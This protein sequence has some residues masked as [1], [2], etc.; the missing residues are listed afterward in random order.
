MGDRE[1]DDLVAA[2]VDRVEAAWVRG[3]LPSRV[4]RRLCVELEQDLS[5]ALDAGA[6][7]AEVLATDPAELAHDVAA[8]AGEHV[9]AAGSGVSRLGLAV[10]GVAGSLVSVALVWFFVLPALADAIYPDTDGG[11]VLVVALV[12]IYGMCLAVVLGGAALSMGTYLRE[13]TDWLPT[14]ARATAAMGA[15]GVLGIPIC[16]G[17]GALSDYSTAPVV[18]LLYLL[19]VGGLGGLGIFLAGRRRSLGVEPASR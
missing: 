16:T 1:R 2:Y 17:I 18:V 7:A 4:R 13:T 6:P 15:L 11:W 8:A 3:G 19:I 5:A 10:R 14:T 12:V 9:V